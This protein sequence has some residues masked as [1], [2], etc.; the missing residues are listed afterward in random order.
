MIKGMLS[1]NPEYRPTVNFILNHAKWFHD[2]ATM[3]K[4]VKDLYASFD[5][6]LNDRL[7]SLSLEGPQ[8]KK[9]RLE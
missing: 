4:R 3:M 7:S 2:D 6:R 5:D 8:A 9:K 1:I